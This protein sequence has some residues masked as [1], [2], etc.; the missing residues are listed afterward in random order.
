M[1]HQNLILWQGAGVLFTGICGVI[2]HFLFAWTNQC[3]LVAPFSAVNESI[4]E[5][6][7]LLFFPMLLFAM[8][9][10]RYHAREILNF[11]C[12]KLV[13]TVFGVVSIPVLYYT[14]NGAFGTM[15][16]WVNI[17]I[18]FVA[19][20]ASFGMET[21]MFRNGAPC[22]FRGAGWA[23]LLLAVLFAVWTFLPP[24]FPLFKD[25]I[26]NTYGI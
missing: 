2:L 24:L 4:W 14:L 26:A 23:F 9:E 15:P 5:H 6:M 13:G 17:A 16:D 22:F 11:W 3:A 10:S 1:K 19:A 21:R 8:A 20:L 18:F 7:K 12:I 25:P